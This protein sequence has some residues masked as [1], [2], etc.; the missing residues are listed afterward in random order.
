MLG[1]WVRASWVHQA[2]FQGR[3]GLVCPGTRLDSVSLAQGLEG[4]HFRRK[5]K[6]PFPAQPA[7]RS[8]TTDSPVRGRGN[9]ATG[10]IG[11]SSKCPVPGSL[12]GSVLGRVYVA[13]LQHHALFSMP[14]MCLSALPHASRYPLSPLLQM[15]KLRG[16]L[17]M[18]VWAICLKSLKHFQ[19]LTAEH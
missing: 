10:S 1:V 3:C 6:R 8:P 13:I 16:P 7:D 15:R 5:G 12:M 17:K 11:L 4:L 9:S 14:S 2:G 19:A 18:K